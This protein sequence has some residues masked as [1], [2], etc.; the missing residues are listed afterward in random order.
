MHNLRPITEISLLCYNHLP[1]IS[2][3][4]L[5]N[6]PWFIPFFLCTK[7]MKSKTKQKQNK[8][9]T[10]LEH[11][12]LGNLNLCS[13]AVVTHTWFQN[14]LPYSLCGFELILATGF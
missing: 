6:N 9:I 11:R 2:T 7:N 5:K 4:E 8:P 13:I 1:D 3:I 14:K 10:R 12:S